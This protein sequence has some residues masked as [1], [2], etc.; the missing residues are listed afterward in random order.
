VPLPEPCLRDQADDWNGSAINRFS[1]TIH[2]L[3]AEWWDRFSHSP[4]TI[5]MIFAGGWSSRCYHPAS[6]LATGDMQVEQ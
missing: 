2:F 6:V 1:W 4:F 5:R 3:G